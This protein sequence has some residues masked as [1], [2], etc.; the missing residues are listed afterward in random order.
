MNNYCTDG[1]KNQAGVAK[2]DNL[3]YCSSIMS[4]HWQCIQHP[5]LTTVILNSHWIHCCSIRQS[6]MQ[7]QQG[8]S[9]LKRFVRCLIIVVQM[10]YET[11]K[12]MITLSEMVYLGM[13][14]IA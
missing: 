7:T 8:H 3:T 1:R 4:M 10:K 12:L 9:T 13:Y 6:C 14:V 5:A 11:E 2:A